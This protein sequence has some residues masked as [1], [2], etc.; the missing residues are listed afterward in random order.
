MKK[1]LYYPGCSLHSTGKAYE[2]SMLRVFRHMEVEVEELKDWNCCGATSY[3]SIDEMQA[4]ALAARNLAVAEYQNGKN[5]EPTQLLTPCNACYLVLTKTQK[6]MGTYPHVQE[7][8]DKALAAAELHYEGKVKVRHPLDVITNDIGL[9]AVTEKVTKNLKGLRVA[10]YYGCQ[11]VRPFAEFDDQHNPMTMDNLVTA[12]GGEAVDW[13]LKTRC[14]S[15]SLTGTIPEAGLRLNRRLLVEAVKRGAEMIITC[16]PLCQFNL[17]CFQDK[18]NADYGEHIHI[19]VMYFTQLMGVAFGLPE[20][21]LGIQ[22]LF[23]K[24]EPHH[25]TTSK[26]AVKTHA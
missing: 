23:V 3:A 14:C 17:E 6:Y 8:V 7:K 15:G 4:F 25:F 12:L 24:P 5:G 9:K 2:E 20:T 18:I 16:C 1:Y 21:E 22:R 19:P 11:I 13:P 10:S 26:G